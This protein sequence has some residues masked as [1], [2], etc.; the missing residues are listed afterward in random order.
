VIGLVYQ[1]ATYVTVLH[2]DKTREGG[3]ILTRSLNGHLLRVFLGLE[4]I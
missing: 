1:C 4:N 3:T 2:L